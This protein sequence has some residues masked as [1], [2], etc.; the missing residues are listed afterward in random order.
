MIIIFQSKYTA[1]MRI[2]PIPFNIHKSQWAT[3]INRKCPIVWLFTKYTN[4]R[5]IMNSFLIF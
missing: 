5:C 4:H 1:T 2:L 3:D